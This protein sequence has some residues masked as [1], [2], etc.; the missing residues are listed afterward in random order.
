MAITLRLRFIGLC[1]FVQ[2]DDITHV[3]LPPTSGHA[4]GGAGGHGVGGH[5][6]AGG[7]PT[8]P[9]HEAR[10]FLA[11]PNSANPQIPTPWSMPLD[12]CILRIRD[13]NR[14]SGAPK[15][16]G[17]LFNVSALAGASVQPAA[18]GAAP[19]ANVAHARVDLDLH[20]TVAAYGRAQYEIPDSAGQPTIV[21]HRTYTEWAETANDG[22][23]EITLEYL[24]GGGAPRVVTLVPP[25]DNDAHQDIS[26]SLAIYHVPVDEM[27]PAPSKKVELKTAVD[28]FNAYYDVLD[29]PT[30]RPLPVLQQVIDKAPVLGGEVGPCPNSYAT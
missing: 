8:M 3:L 14:A 17:E 26:L 28:H 10:L 22:D 6:A 20:G 19:P 7:G 23:I 5:H 13:R 9:P 1:M 24:D 18:L 2:R 12:R 21:V 4:H 30:A 15:L 27:P 16:P 25:A 29:Q 11:W